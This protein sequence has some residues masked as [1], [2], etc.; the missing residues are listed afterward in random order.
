MRKVI[1]L[2][3]CFCFIFEQT[4]FA[5]I[6][7]NFPVPAYLN[8]FNSAGKFRP[9]HMRSM[10]FDP[11]SDKFNMLLDKGDAKEV[12]TAEAEETAIR[13]FEYFQ[14]GLAL[15]NSCFW[16]NLRPDSPKDVI[17]PYLENTDLGRVLLEADLLLKKD[18]ARFTSIDTPEG[19]QYWDRLYRKAESLYGQEDMTIPTL[20][21]PWIVP[22][23]IILGD[24]K[25]G[26]YIYKAMLNVMLEQDYLKDSVMFTF[27]DDRA[28][29]VND[30]S[31]ELIRQ[32]ILPKLIR[33]VNSSKKYAGLRQVYY[34]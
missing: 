20:T 5:Q 3:V 19:R 32:L 23:E 31:S 17:D 8:S 34:S 24:S 33:E 21:R 27:D 18:I 12:A 30:Y 1:A 13:L 11:Q 6:A 28:K 25:D 2:L 15:P 26:V 10:M 29:Q 16:V 7:G 9:I 14:L 22:G 4:G